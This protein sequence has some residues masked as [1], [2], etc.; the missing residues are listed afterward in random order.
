[1]PRR[2]NDPREI[3][4]KRDLGDRDGYGRP[5]KDNPVAMA[6]KS[7]RERKEKK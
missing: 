2:I 1:M 7:V 3:Q 4:P 6:M 5:L